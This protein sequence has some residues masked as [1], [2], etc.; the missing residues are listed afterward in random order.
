MSELKIT[1]LGIPFIDSLLGGGFLSNSII[2]ISHQPGS[3]IRHLGLQIG[4]NKFNEKLHLINVTFHYSLREVTDWLKVY[5]TNQE[6][7]KRVREIR[8]ISGVSTID[9]F[10]I[11]EVEEDSQIGNV[12]YVSNPFNIDNLLSV[13]AK[14]RESIPED[15]PVYWVFYHLTNMNIG[16]SENELLKFCRRAFRYH[17]M[18]GD[19]A[20][21]YLNENAHTDMFFAKL[22]QLSDVFIKVVAEET[23]TGLINGVQV[24]KGVFPFDS[25]KVFFDVNEK[26]MIEIKSDKKDIEPP[27]PTESLFATGYPETREGIEGVKIIRTGIPMFDSLLGG[28]MLSN[29]IIV[30]TN[31]YGIRILEP[32]THIFTSPLEGNAHIININYHFSPEEYDLRLKIL[33][34]KTE[35]HKIPLKSFQNGNISIIDCLNIQRGRSEEPRGNIYPISNPFDVDRVLTVMTKVR[36]S[37]PD[38]KPVFWIFSSL[39]DMSIGLSEKDLVMFCRKAFRYHKYCGDL[40]LYMLTEQAHSERFQAMLYQLS[41]IFIKFRGQE[42]KEGIDTSLQVMKGVFKFSSKKTKYTLDN[43][44]QI[45]FLEN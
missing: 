7:Y 17:K 35:I 8:P 18:H 16:V 3:K 29:S 26:G 36:N 20:F 38:E 5:T 1:N 32:L 15:Q 25:K 12:Y 27:K 11:S 33:S 6:V 30:A 43:K 9:C 13:M 28:G 4:L 22:Y 21:Y 37:V 31:Q 44:G 19:L 10:N 41:D 40:A 39:T 23:S 14:V 42:T 45:Q 34:Q 24:I 2:V